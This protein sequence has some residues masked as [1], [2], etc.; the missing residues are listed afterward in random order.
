MSDVK[1][2]LIIRLSSFGD[3]VLTYPF[4]NELRRLYPDAAI[5]MVSKPQYT[6]LVKLHP[7]INEAIPFD[8]NMKY[9]LDSRKFDVVFDLQ[10]NINSRRIIPSGTKVIRVVKES[11]KKLLLVHF[12]VNLLKEYIPVYKKYL[13]ALKKFDDRADTGFTKTDLNLKPNGFVSDKYIVLS[14]SSKHFTKRLPESKFA[15]L[16][17]DLKTKVIITGDNNETDKE[18][19]VYFDTQFNNSLNLCGKLSFPELADVIKGAEFVVCNDS[20]ILHLAEALGKKVFVFFGSTVKEFGFF[21]QLDTSEVEE[22]TGLN[23]RP[24]T[25]IGRK[26]CPKGHFKCMNDID[27]KQI[28]LKINEYTE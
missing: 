18:I 19:C 6:D 21:P 2:I 16:L 7:F 25:H 12:K 17:K 10:R 28:R 11:W 26:D 4:I 3:I 24:C 13:N 14:P 1:K 8:M 27:V 15:L 23:C 9:Y 20:G 22:V 5:D